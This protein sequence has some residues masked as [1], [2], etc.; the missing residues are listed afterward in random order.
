MMI[1]MRMIIVMMMISVAG[2]RLE[3]TCV[4]FQ[5]FTESRSCLSLWTSNINLHVR[6]RQMHPDD[7]LICLMDLW[8]ACISDYMHISGSVI[9]HL[10]NEDLVLTCIAEAN[11]EVLNKALFTLG[12]WFV[13]FPECEL[14]MG[15]RQHHIRGSK[16]SWKH[17]VH[18]Q[19][20]DYQWEHR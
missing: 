3:S 7:I 12:I 5:T 19:T 18:Y 4:T 1:L 15:E 16:Q 2:V 14:F 11:P 8:V 6:I 10:E 9:P 20:E 17:G 13:F